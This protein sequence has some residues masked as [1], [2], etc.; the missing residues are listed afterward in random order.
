M[1]IGQ[2]FN[3]AGFPSFIHAK[4]NLFSMKN[5]AFI[6]VLARTAD[7]YCLLLADS[8]FTLVESICSNSLFY[9]SSLSGT[10]V[11]FYAAPCQSIYGH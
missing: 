11:S 9:S 10:E 4:P 5:S 6:G 7:E 3:K 1:F 8:T 2:V